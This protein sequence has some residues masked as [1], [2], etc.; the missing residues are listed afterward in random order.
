MR[1]PEHYVEMTHEQIPG[2]SIYVAP[3]AVP[4]HE[5][6]GWRRPEAELDEHAA[7]HGT[8]ETENEE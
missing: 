7:D 2:R 8:S 4:H 1:R 3:E 5:R 6:A